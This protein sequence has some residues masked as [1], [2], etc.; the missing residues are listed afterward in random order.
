MKRQGIAVVAMMIV[1]AAAIV[2][3]ASVAQAR[4]SNTRSDV[5]KHTRA[6]IKQARGCAAI[7]NLSLS[8]AASQNVYTA[9]ETV[10][11]AA[12]T[13]DAIRSRLSTMSTDH[14]DK[15]ALTAWAGVDRLKSGLNA[16]VAF[17]DTQ[18][19]SKLAE[20]KGKLRQ[21]SSWVRIGVRGI[22]LRRH[23]YGLGSI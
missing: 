20:A 11:Q 19:P 4:P 21:G 17:L 9:V 13:C 5:D 7:A 16:T 18:I 22:N 6:Y 23:V 1:V 2:A 12:D 3:T 8:V 10:K 15:Q 14:F